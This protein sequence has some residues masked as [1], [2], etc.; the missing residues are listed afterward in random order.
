M[1]YK[2]RWR[3]IDVVNINL[4]HSLGYYPSLMDGLFGVNGCYVLYCR[5]LFLLLSARGQFF[6]TVLHC[7]RTFQDN[8]NSQDLFLPVTLLFMYKFILSDAYTWNTVSYRNNFLNKN[9]FCT[10]NIR[11]WE[12][13]ISTVPGIRIQKIA[14]IHK[15]FLGWNESRARVCKRLWS[16]GIDSSE[17]I[18]PGWESTPGLLKRSK[19]T[20]SGLEHTLNTD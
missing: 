20:G 1:L 2:A 5:A 12:F 8:D 4:Q 18:P 11:T 3:F 19:N 9:V 15:R 16:P 6:L 10:Y 17:S 7:T 14:W 13:W